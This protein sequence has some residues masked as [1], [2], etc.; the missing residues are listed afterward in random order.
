MSTLGVV[1]AAGGTGGHIYPMLA[2]I[3]ALRAH[4]P[5]DPV[6]LCSQRPIDATVLTGAGQTP[7]PIPARPLTPKSLASLA[8]NWGRAVRESREALR[9]LRARTG[10]VAMLTTGGFVSAPAAQA[11]R[12]EGVPIVL[13]AMDAIPG[14]ASRFVARRATRRL[15]VYDLHG[16]E[17]VGPVVRAEALPTLDPSEARARLGL[18][19]ALPTWLITGGSQGAR[20]LNELALTLARAHPGVLSGWQ[21]LHQVGS[22]DEA[23]V[24]SAWEALGVRAVVRAL[25]RPMGDAWAAADLALCRAGAGTVAE[26]WAARVPSVLL[27][28]P[29]HADQHQSANARPL[30]EV[31]GARLHTDRLGGEENLADAGVSLL[32]L[33]GG[34]ENR[35][36][37]RAGLESLPVPGGAARVAA[38]LVECATSS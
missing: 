29:F 18:D 6:W 3:D 35:A 28:Y 27:P 36:E 12:L 10:R 14:K 30:V 34:S 5:V 23:S 1:C 16:Y 19:P 38:A 31:G 2:A 25:V 11:A 24:R 33:L 20:T 22:D 17:Q 7:T 21:V 26:L 8:W 32:E 9:A 15:A 37:M 4:T 13:L